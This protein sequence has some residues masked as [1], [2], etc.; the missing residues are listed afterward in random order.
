MRRVAL[1]L[2]VPALLTG[3]SVAITLD[4]GPKLAATPVLSPAAR[5]QAI[6][7]HLQAHRVQAMFFVTARNGADRPEGQA[8]LKALGEGGQLLANHTVSHPDFNT[9][10]VTLEAFQAE[11]S[12]C[13]ALIRTQP[14][15]R[16]FMRFPYLREGASAAKR[17]GIR[18]WLRAQDYRIGYVSIDSS[19]WL[20]D[21]KLCEKLARDPKAGPAPFRALYLDHI[22]E[23]AQVYDRLARALYGRPVP[24]VLLLHHNLLN[25]L[26]LGD[27]LAMFEAR[28]WTFV[29]PD[30]AFQDPAYRVE[31]DILPLDG[32]VLESTARALGVPLKPFFQ[33]IH[34]ERAIGE[35][36]GKL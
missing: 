36:A 19:D 25:A 32:S 35:M 1:F 9:E 21:A 23:Y 26:F 30:Q 31:P 16:K 22:W 11:V 34:R 20:I 14:G 28:G 6:L 7:G 10:A 12:G 13:D 5:N 3:Q 29:S 4:D 8:L 15:Y 18:A 24:H 17:D 33:G 27:L 2:A